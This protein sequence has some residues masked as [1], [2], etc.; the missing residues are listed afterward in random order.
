M[1]AYQPSRT[2]HEENFTKRDAFWKT[3]IRLFR[4]YLKNEAKQN[5][6]SRQT[7]RLSVAEQGRAFCSMFEVP[8]QLMAE[9]H[10]TMALLVMVN[11]HKITRRKELLPEIKTFLG[12]DENEI[13]Q[14]YSRI[15]LDNNA[16]LRS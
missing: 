8:G 7:R 14:R 5:L 11:S 1:A 2:S 4:R 10:T 13:I 9:S 3:V 6:D 15:F 12:R 16:Q